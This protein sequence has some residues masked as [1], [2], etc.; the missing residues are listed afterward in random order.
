MG[1]RREEDRVRAMHLHMRLRP[2]L[3]DGLWD[4]Q[5]AHD[6]QELTLLLTGG[7]PAT[8]EVKDDLVSWIALR[9]RS[10]RAAGDRRVLNAGKAAGRAR[11]AKRTKG[12]RREARER[13]QGQQAQFRSAMSR[14]TSLIDAL[15]RLGLPPGVTD[16]EVEKLM[17]ENRKL[18]AGSLASLEEKAELQRHTE[19]LDRRVT[20]HKESVRHRPVSTEEGPAAS[21]LVDLE[22]LHQEFVSTL[23]SRLG[24][25]TVADVDRLRNRLLLKVDQLRAQYWMQLDDLQRTRLARLENKAKNL[26]A[27]PAWSAGS[28]QLLQGGLPSLGQKR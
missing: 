10:T 22:R 6:L 8:R 23:R 11:R 7:T 24:K 28:V 18:L 5:A 19:R 3:K 12:G 15:P 25:G 20:F 2:L 14:T 16:G 1:S 21:A 13:R 17:D 26:K 4:E 27:P 9:T